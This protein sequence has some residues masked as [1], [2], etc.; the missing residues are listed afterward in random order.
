MN[1]ASMYMS[2]AMKGPWSVDEDE[3]G[4][5]THCTVEASSTTPYPVPRESH[6]ISIG[7]T[8]SST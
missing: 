2:D 8:A 6:V 4:G 7:A 3:V 1:S 5:A